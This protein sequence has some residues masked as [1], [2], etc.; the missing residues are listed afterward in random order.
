MKKRYEFCRFELTE[1][2]AIEA[3][4][5]KMAAKGW[6]LDRLGGMLWR[7][8]AAPPQA[9]RYAV[10][11]SAGDTS[12]FDGEPTDAQLEYQAYCE[13]AGWRCAAGLAYF[14]IFCTDQPDAP[15]LETDETVKLT[16]LRR[17]VL[18]KYLPPQL[19]FLLVWTVYLALLI[20][21][22]RSRPFDFL[23]S[24]MTLVFLLGYPLLF[25][26]TLAV[27]LRCALWYV[28]SRRAVAAGGS[29]LR[30]S[31]RFQ[32]A[33][34]AGLCVLLALVLAA[35]IADFCTGDPGT[36]A[37]GLYI[38]IYVA[39]LMSVKN[40]VPLFLRRRDCDRTASRTVYAVAAVAAALVLAF[41][42]PDRLEYNRVDRAQLP[43]STQ[44]LGWPQG[45]YIPYIR[46]DYSRTPL[47]DFLQG[48]DWAEQDLTYR[49]YRSPWPYLL[50]AIAESLH[51]V[52]AWTQLPPDPA[53]RGGEVW[54]R[55]GF[56][57]AAVYCAAYPGVVLYLDYDIPPT[58]EQIGI[59]L[60]ALLP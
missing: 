29:C 35:L 43:L 50:G 8:A 32:R 39:V 22:F 58:P 11:Y 41:S 37:E 7:Y 18:R 40:L 13:A 38:L 51:D 19:I 48:S 56:E 28:R 9:L 26:N 24:H 12:V 3:H 30:Q 44:D 52:P 53:W 49:R 33:Q 23:R 6:Q 42:R 55:D 17:M 14:Q 5:A 10:V 34:Q 21:V 25:L 47:L 46:L 36:R 4:L 57:G 59:T 54:Y 16:S 27:I 31:G 1:P 60:D 20:P 2:E 45:E 15:P